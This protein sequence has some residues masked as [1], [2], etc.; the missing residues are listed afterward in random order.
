MVVKNI[1]IDSYFYGFSNNDFIVTFDKQRFQQIA[2]NFL[3]NAVKFIQSPN[4]IRMV[5]LKINGSDPVS[6]GFNY[7]N[8]L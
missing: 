4:K 7:F 8:T 1:K 6:K 3:S 2:L 5:L